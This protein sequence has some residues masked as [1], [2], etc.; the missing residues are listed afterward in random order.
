MSIFD[1]GHETGEDRMIVFGVKSQLKCLEGCRVL[2]CEGTFATVPTLTFQLYTI[3]GLVRDI[4]PRVLFALLPCK[5]TA[6]YA[7][8]NETLIKHARFYPRNIY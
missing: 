4:A 7:K 6:T 5:T 3:H 8:L 1:S 2:N